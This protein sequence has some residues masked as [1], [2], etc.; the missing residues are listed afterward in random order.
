[1]PHQNSENP[2]EK[3]RKKSIVPLDALVPSLKTI[4]EKLQKNS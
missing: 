4:S 2:N 3:W 1:M